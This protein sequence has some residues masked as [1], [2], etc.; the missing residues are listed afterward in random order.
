[1]KY[2]KCPICD[3]N[4]VTNDE[5]YCSVCQRSLEIDFFHIVRGYV[6]GNN[7]Q[8]IYEKFCDTLGWDRTKVNKFGWHT[9]LYAEN[10]DT[11]RT[12][13]VWFI[14]YPNYDAEKINSVVD[15]YHVVNLIKNNGDNIIE[16]VENRLG[17]S[18]NANRITFVKTSSGYKFFGVYKI[19][20]N[21]TTR[22]YQRISDIY[23]M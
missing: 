1:M 10:A 18:N 2:K 6:Y 22:L 21:G 16:V 20:H 4:Y 17:K 11:D 19:I 3:L 5:K 23:P 15:D 9:P 8:Q 14:F 12:N 13:D 7:S